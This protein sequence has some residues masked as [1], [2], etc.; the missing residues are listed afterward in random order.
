MKGRRTAV[1]KNHVGLRVEFADELLH[2]RGLLVEY[3]E[4]EKKYKVGAE[5]RRGERSAPVLR[6]R[7]KRV[8]SAL[9]KAHIWT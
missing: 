2:V 4:G 5:N 1:Y 3:C 6:S 8:K 7:K 9:R